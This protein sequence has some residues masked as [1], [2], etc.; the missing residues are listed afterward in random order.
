MTKEISIIS[1]GDI[2]LSD[3]VVVADPCYSRDEESIV[4]DVAVKPGKYATYIVKNNEGRVAS[5]IAVHED[6]IASSKAGWELDDRFIGVDSGQC[7]IFDNTVYPANG[8]SV[9]EY[10]DENSFYGECCKL[11]LSK[12]NGG[13]L[14]SRNGVVSSS[15]YGDGQ[16]K[17]FY[18]YRENELVALMVDFGL[19]VNIAIM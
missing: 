15:G 9:G 17:L 12:A 18:Q 2:V 3:K 8:K 4:K 1:A 5:V 14:K 6:Y 11:T 19:K 10:N 13:I 16:Y 7:G